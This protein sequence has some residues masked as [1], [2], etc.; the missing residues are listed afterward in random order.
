MDGREARGKGEERVGNPM[1]SLSFFESLINEKY[2]SFEKF[3]EFFIYCQ[4]TGV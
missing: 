1:T 4:T 3:I 2:L